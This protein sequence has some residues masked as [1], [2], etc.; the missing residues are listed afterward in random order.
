VLRRQRRAVHLVREHGVPR[1]V[2][3]ETALVLLLDLLLETAVDPGEDDL[4]SVGAARPPPATPPALRLAT[5]QFRRPR[6]A[7]AG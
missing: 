2:E 7:T 4:S 1:V 3:P 5:A 6:S